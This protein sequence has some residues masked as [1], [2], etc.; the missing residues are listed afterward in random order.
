VDAIHQI[1]DTNA[2]AFAHFREAVQQLRASFPK[3]AEQPYVIHLVAIKERASLTAEEDAAIQT[4]FATIRRSLNPSAVTLPDD[5]R[6][7]TEAQMSVAEYFGTW[8]IYL[9][10]LT[11]GGEE[12]DRGRPTEGAY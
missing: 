10:Y 2:Q 3:T 5:L 9:D 1:A 6:I 4:I 7:V 11:Y 8:P 12:T